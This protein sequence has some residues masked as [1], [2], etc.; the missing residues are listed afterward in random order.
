MG[1]SAYPGSIYTYKR[2]IINVFIRRDVYYTLIMTA[3]KLQCEKWR[4]QIEFPV[5]D[6]G[7]GLLNL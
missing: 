3:I 5:E 1:Q 2:E 7:M 4:I 6:Y